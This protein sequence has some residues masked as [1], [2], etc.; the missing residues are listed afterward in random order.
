[1]KRAEF[2]SDGD[3][4]YIGLISGTSMDGVDA[5]LLEIDEGSCR[6]L[7]GLT[8]PYPTQLNMRLHAAI[9]PDVRL[10]LDEIASLNI[11]VGEWF[12]AAATLLLEKS[13]TQS[14]QAIAVG[15]HGQTLR[16]APRAVWPYSL[17]IGS[18]AVIAA[19]LG[20]TTV[21]DFRSL[22]I[23]YGGE[24][25]PLVP[26]FHEWLLRDP[27]ENRVIANIGGIAN[28]SLLPSGESSPLLGYDTGPGNCLMD[29]WC[30]RHQGLPYDADGGW[31]AAGKV[32]EALLKALLDDSYY[33]AG[34]PKST[35]RE[36]FNLP[37]LEPFLARIA[38]SSLAPIDV[39]ATLAQ[40]TIESLAREVERH[41]QGW[42]TKLFVCGGGAHNAHLMRQL[43]ARLSP[44]AIASVSA[45]GIDPDLVEACAFAW[46]AYM[47]LQGRPVRMT[48]GTTAREIRLGGVYLPTHLRID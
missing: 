13:G 15:S 8:H 23:A 26:A 4:L 35:G 6:T 34:P 40:L 33:A 1:M 3:G 36:V 27:N 31:A 5:V 9:A 12:A 16:H 14:S 29:S 41:G 2:D 17:Q 44:V 21:A 25:A 37:Y 43:A 39:Q 32:N 47:R 46:L 19:R 10:S 11:A 28:I 7:G 42:A 18:P 45:L 30:A 24:G 20:L 22:D 48:T 38:C